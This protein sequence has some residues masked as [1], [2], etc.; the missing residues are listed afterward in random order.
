MRR[1]REAASAEQHPP[2]V[3]ASLSDW[4][5]SA[6]ERHPGDPAEPA[7]TA[8]V[9]SAAGSGLS[10]GDAVT[11]GGSWQAQL[12][13]AIMAV[14]T[15]GVPLGLS[16]SGVLGRICHVSLWVASSPVLLCTFQFLIRSHLE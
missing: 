16:R 10:L 15:A 13:A 5:L 14:R 9:A 1:L 11:C 6:E 7:S 12:T 8:R 2:S 3:A 4:L